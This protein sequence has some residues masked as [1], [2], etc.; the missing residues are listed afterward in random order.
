MKIWKYDGKTY[1]NFED[2]RDATPDVCYCEQTLPEHLGEIGISVEEIPDPE[3]DPLDAAKN[4]RR[5][6]VDGI[7]VEVDGMVFDGNEIAQSR[8]ISK[9]V[10][11]P[12]GVD[13]IDWVLSDDSIASVTRA[14][15]QNALAMA[16][17]AMQALWLA[18]YNTTSGA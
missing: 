18:P 1:E 16:G 12:E 15:L 8:M 2:L 7:R 3:P 6:A 17:K 5:R 13:E 10:G 14:Q 4:E 9:I 11:W